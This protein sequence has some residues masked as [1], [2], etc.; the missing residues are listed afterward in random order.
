MSLRFPN[1]VTHL[2][3]CRD[4]FISAIISLIARCRPFDT[5]VVYKGPCD[6]RDLRL[7][8]EGNILVE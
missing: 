3:V 5:T 4:C 8:D 6:V 1:E 2:I 7:K